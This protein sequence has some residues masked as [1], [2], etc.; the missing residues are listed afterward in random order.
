[1]DSSRRLAPA[2]LLPLIAGCAAEVVRHPI[3]LSP[4]QPRLFV[5]ERAVQVALDSGYSRSLPGGAEFIDIGSIRQGRVL[6]PARVVITVEGA[7]VHEAYPVIESGRVVGFY[8]PVERA[9]AP[10]S[11]PVEFP[12]NER[13]QP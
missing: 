11:S 10:V 1:M 4:G 2:F 8:L 6:K 5:S 7:H 9:F 13:R 3:E 12:V